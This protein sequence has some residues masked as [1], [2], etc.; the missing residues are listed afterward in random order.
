MLIIENKQFFQLIAHEIIDGVNVTCYLN[1]LDKNYKPLIPIYSGHFS[2]F[3]KP[4]FF[5]I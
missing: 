2:Y 3:D 4:K 1:K 5:I